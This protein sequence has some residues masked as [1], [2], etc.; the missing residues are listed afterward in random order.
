VPRRYALKKFAGREGNTPRITNIGT[1]PSIC[2]IAQSPTRGC[3]CSTAIR[4]S[5]L[6]RKSLP[7][8]ELTFS[9]YYP[10]ILLQVPCL[11]YTLYC[12]YHGSSVQETDAITAD[13][14]HFTDTI[15]AHV[16]T[17]LTLSR[18][19][20]ALHWHFHSW[21]I[22]PY[23]KYHGSCTYFTDI[24]TVLVWTLLKL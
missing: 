14:L 24:T 4:N 23:W 15:A 2:L 7:R 1:F 5:E 20:F 17:S 6:Y 8:T 13:S 3:A 21:C 9:S 22:A 18:F 11:I 10:F 19:L 12:Q 16:C